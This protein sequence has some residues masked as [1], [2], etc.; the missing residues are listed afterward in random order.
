[1]NWKRGITAFLTG[2]ILLTAL[3]G[4]GAQ[5]ADGNGGGAAAEQGAVQPEDVKEV[6]SFSLA[7]NKS[8]SLN[9][10]TCTSVENKLLLQLCFES[11]FQLDESFE[12]QAELCAD[13][14]QNSAKSYTLTLQSGI[15]FHSG[16]EMTVEDVVYSLNNARQRENSVYQ[17]QLACISSVKYDDD[18][19]N[20]RLNR[21]KSPKELEALLNVPIF[22][23]GSEEEEIL[24]GSGPYQIVSS[25]SGMKLIPFDAWSG[26][27]VGF[28]SSIELKSVSDNSG[29]ANLLS[30]GDLSLLLQQ[31]AESTAV[32]GAKYTA[33]VPTTRLHYLGINCEWEPLDDPDVRTALSMLMDRSSI[34]RTCFTGRADAASLP[35]ASIPEGV[36]AFDYNKEDALALLE[37]A[38]IYD[39]DDDGYLDISSTKQF[40]VEIIYNAAYGTK[41]AVLDQYVKNL[42]EVGIQ[43]TVTPLEFEDCRAK[44]RRESFQLY[45]GEYEMT[46]DFD[47]SSVISRN[48]ERNFGTYSSSKMENV[49]TALHTADE[50]EWE[51]ARADYLEC[52]MEETPIIPIA[53]ERSLISSADQLPAG[54]A[55]W[56]YNVFHG[57]EGWS[58][59]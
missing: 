25:D 9:P 19:I 32:T 57:I 29:A 33:S 3:A 35:V 20:I 51:D 43:V 17:E 34:V 49:L 18:T 41:G 39:R 27:T 48:G 44:L 50:T 10:L 52:F 40:T 14:E 36:D 38:G 24:D 47:L 42:N 23:K 1:M 31:D 22:R 28:C 58:A 46:A 59:S 54:F 37:D 45:Y 6:D 30:S 11:L 21:S 5:T 12:P 7:Y 4:C 26:G 16:E 15:K 55:P 8:D 56:P 13:I 53:F 2:A